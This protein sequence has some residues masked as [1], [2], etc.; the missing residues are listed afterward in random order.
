MN[1][2]TFAE[3]TWVRVFVY[4]NKPFLSLEEITLDGKETPVEGWMRLDE[5]ENNEEISFLYSSK[6]S[7][8]EGTS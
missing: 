6:E 5:F 8:I 3:V 1:T 7:I 2:F 4:Y